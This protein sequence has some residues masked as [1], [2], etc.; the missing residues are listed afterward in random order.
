[1]GT[2]T[3][4]DNFSHLAKCAGPGPR[5]PHELQQPRG[6]LP[7]NI[8]EIHGHAAIAITKDTWSVDDTRAAP[9]AMIGAPFGD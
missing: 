5:H 9:E 2:P 7:L 3:T 8:P 6:S 1:M 4:P